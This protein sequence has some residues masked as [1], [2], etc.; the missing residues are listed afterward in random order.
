[1]ARSKIIIKYDGTHFFGWQL[2]QGARTVQ[3]VLEKALVALSGGDRII[4]NG[5]GRTDSG[6]HAFGQ[7]AHFD[8]ETRLDDTTLLDAM[9]GHLPKDCRVMQVQ[10]EGEDFHARYSAVKRHYRYQC[11]SK[12]KLVY[13][14]QVWMTNPLNIDK[15]NQVASLFLGV[16]DFLSFSKYNEK[17]EHTNCIIDS[18]LWKEEGDM[19]IFNIS[20]NRFLHHMVRYIVGC[21]VQ[22]ND[23]KMSFN[24]IKNLLDS[25]RKDVQ[26]FKAPAQGL[27]LNHVDYA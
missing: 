5:A 17:L 15:L 3:G 21:S 24:T 16:H 10:Q 12:K 9:N 11:M 14:N 7:V 2:R 23:G 13:G 4:V 6:V 18:A 27:F 25:P 20:A 26:I 22:N 8:L 1:M 19:L